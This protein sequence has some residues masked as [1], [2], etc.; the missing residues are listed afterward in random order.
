MTRHVT[1][2]DKR[3]NKLAVDEIKAVLFIIGPPSSAGIELTV[4]SDCL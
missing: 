1:T 2:S 4:F 3:M